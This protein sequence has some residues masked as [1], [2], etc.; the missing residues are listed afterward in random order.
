M[1]KY[2]PKNPAWKAKTPFETAP[3]FR[4]LA[5]HCMKHYVNIQSLIDEANSARAK[6]NGAFQ[7]EL[8]AL[9]SLVLARNALMESANQFN[10]AAELYN[11]GLI[12]RQNEEAAEAQKAPVVNPPSPD[13]VT[14]N[15]EEDNGDV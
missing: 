1:P 8:Q 6:Y 7:E 9:G 12:P 11:T 15:I 13:M 14:V 3:V 5:V 2:N 10:A 4:R